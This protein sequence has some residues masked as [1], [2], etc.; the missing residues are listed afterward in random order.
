[1]DGQ[2]DPNY[3][4]ALLKKKWW[5]IQVPYNYNS[6]SWWIYIYSLGYLQFLVKNQFTIIR[7]QGHQGLSK[8]KMF[9]IHTDANI[10]LKFKTKLNLIDFYKF[11]FFY[12]IN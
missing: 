3:K 4:K 10:K 6:V 7:A 2:T 5:Y 12:I 8:S 11:Y 9:A 1:M